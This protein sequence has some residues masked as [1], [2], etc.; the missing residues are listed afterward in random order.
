MDITE[1]QHRSR[2]MGIQNSALSL[3]GVLGPFLIVFAARVTTA[4]GI[5]M[6]AGSLVLL[7]GLLALFLLH[8]HGK[9]QQGVVSL[10]HDPQRIAAAHAVLHGL[11]IHATNQRTHTI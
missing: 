2:I 5:F 11:T 8:E 6:V 7:S 9:R 1:E 10:T 4:H 3:G